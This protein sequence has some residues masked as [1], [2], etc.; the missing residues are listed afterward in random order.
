M[1]EDVAVDPHGQLHVSGTIDFIDVDLSDTHFVAAGLVSST[2]HAGGIALGTL[3]PQLTTDTVNGLGGA[4][5]WQYLVDDSAIQFLRAGQ[6]VIETY[7]VTIGDGHGGSATRNVA[8]TITGSEDARL[9]LASAI[10][11]E[12]VNA[13]AQH[14]ALSGTLAVT[15]LDVGDTLTA[16]ILHAPAVTLDGAAF[17]L[18]VGRHR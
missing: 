14:I 11:A 1:T 10:A 16:S 6:T 12:D 15:D 5:K 3:S 7:A 17:A 9:W 2:G 8:V 13:A 4:V 18:P